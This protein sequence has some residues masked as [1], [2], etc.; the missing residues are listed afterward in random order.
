MPTFYSQQ[1]PEQKLATVWVVML[2]A[3]GVIWLGSCGKEESEQHGSGEVEQ[4]LVPQLPSV[5]FEYSLLG[6]PEEWLTDPA[7]Q[8]FGNIGS[9]IGITDDGATL[10]RVL[11]YDPILSSDGAV[12][13]AS[14]H[15]QANAFAD[16]APHSIGV[17]GVPTERN[18]MGL[19][20]FRYQR[21]FFWDM[22]TV[23]LEEQVLEPIAHPDEM[24]L[25]LEDLPGRLAAQSYYPE[26]FGAAFESTDVTVERVASALTQFLMSMRSYSS[27]YDAGRANGFVNFS[28][29]ELAGKSIFFNGDS[30]CNQCHSG[31][32]LFS[33][34][35]F[36]NGLEVDYEAAGD[37]GI[38]ELSGDPFDDGRFKTVSLRNIGLTA[39][40]MHD[41]RFSSLREVVDFYADDIQHHPFLD[42]RLGV[43]GF[44]TPGQA[45][46]QLTLSDEERMALVDFLNTFNDTLMTSSW[47]LSDPF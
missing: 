40:Y 35:P 38:G 15:S 19:F 1:I 12:S 22:R 28:E 16:N 37:G 30:R 24:A 5:P 11:F 34:Q 8:I 17:S 23:G 14:C 41:G 31:L 39:P 26:L 4:S 43:S 32:N 7:L 21:R 45:P 20:N 33:N 29:S 27:R 47:W 44:G 42:E 2:A 6:F 36:I 18:A 10:G 3:V 13:C 46:F 25:K 9:D